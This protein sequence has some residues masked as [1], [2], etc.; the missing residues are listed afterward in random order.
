MLPEHYLTAGLDALA[1]SHLTPESNKAFGDGHRGA[2]M[3]SALFMVE[4]GLIDARAEAPIRY[5]ADH[6]LS[7]PVFAPMAPEPAA[8]Q[9]LDRLLAALARS[10]VTYQSHGV[11]FPSL[12]LRAFRQRPDLITH[13]RI[14][15]LLRIAEAY[16]PTEPSA[17]PL[18]ADIAPRPYAAGPFADEV[19]AGFVVST[20]AYRGFFQGYSGHILTHGQ[21]IHDLH[22]CGYGSLARKAEPGFRA[23]MADCALGLK[24]PN[25]VLNFAVTESPTTSIRPD[26]PDFW[27]SLTW[28]G[29]DF[30]KGLGHILKYAYAF[31]TLSR[32]ATDA[33][34]LARAREMYFVTAW[35]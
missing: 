17:E 6:W 8:P 12:A 1:R 27:L 28:D 5:L 10:M 21:A 31:T 30:A 19:L 2:A 32:H 15:G 22:A 34:G 7:W 29:A 20:R 4:D 16:T 26:Q 13:S 11:I 18:P 9:E 3:L 25:N 14:E 35:G 23:Y 24:G 33:A